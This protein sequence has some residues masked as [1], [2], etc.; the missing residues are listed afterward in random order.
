MRSYEKRNTLV[1]E[2]EDIV[3][4]QLVFQFALLIIAKSARIRMNNGA[5]LIIGGIN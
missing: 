3:P 2:L 4:R 5:L 1:F